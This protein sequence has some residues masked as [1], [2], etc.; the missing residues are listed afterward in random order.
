MPTKKYI[1]N[2]ILV[3]WLGLIVGAV[4]NLFYVSKGICLTL[5]DGSL[6]KPFPSLTDS[7]FWLTKEKNSLGFSEI[8][9][10]ILDEEI[11]IMEESSFD[12]NKGKYIDVQ[13]ELNALKLFIFSLENL[14][15]QNTLWLI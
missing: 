8:Y 3:S 5:C 1:I 2:C 10:L 7:L 12:P 11:M 4:N 9:F 14:C 15:F 13:L 6:S